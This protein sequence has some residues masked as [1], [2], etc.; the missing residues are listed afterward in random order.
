MLQVGHHGSK[1]STSEYLLS[2]VRP[3]VAIISSGRW[4]PWKFPHYLVMER[5]HRYKSAVE[6]TAVS[7][8]VRVNFFQDRL[9]IQQARTEF[10]P[11]YVRVIGLSKE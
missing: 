3:D 7:G 11:W 9:E 5:F 1:T 8:Q 6:N 2:Q 4:N 10:S